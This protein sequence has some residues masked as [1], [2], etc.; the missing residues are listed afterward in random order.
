[1]EAT[2][3]NIRHSSTWGLGRVCTDIGS[4]CSICSGV[5]NLKT[6]TTPLLWKLLD[7]NSGRVLR[8]SRE[9]VRP[10]DFGYLQVFRSCKK[11]FYSKLNI[12]PL[13]RV[14]ISKL[15][16]SPKRYLGRI[17]YKFGSDI[18]MSSKIVKIIFFK[19]Q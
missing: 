2:F 18:S 15:R 7:R 9:C 12:S 13:M 3:S 6:N 10:I 14:R 8:G 16:Q 17:C 5:K 19:P 11:L 4:D 1:M